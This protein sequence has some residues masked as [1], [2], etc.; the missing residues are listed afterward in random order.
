MFDDLHVFIV[1]LVSVPSTQS[2]TVPWRPQNAAVIM[3]PAISPNSQPMSISA[4]LIGVW[5][6]T[7]YAHCAYAFGAQY[8]AV[9]LVFQWSATLGEA[10][11]TMVEESKSWSRQVEEVTGC[12]QRFSMQELCRYVLTIWVNRSGSIISLQRNYRRPVRRYRHNICC[13]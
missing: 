3:A 9:T 4:W 11:E 13:G 7:K 6:H 12:V 5:S 1:M 2:R 10:A 8:P